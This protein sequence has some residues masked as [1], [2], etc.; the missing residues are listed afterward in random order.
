MPY[1]FV[2]F[3]CR[4]INGSP[5][6][7]PIEYGWMIK[8]TS[9][10]ELF[11]FYFKTIEHRAWKCYDDYDRHTR[12]RCHYTE[13]INH[14]MHYLTDNMDQGYFQR[15]SSLFGKGFDAMLRS[16]MRCGT[17]YINRNYG[18]FVPNKGIFEGIT[19][20]NENLIWPEDNKVNVSKFLDGKHYYAIVN[21]VSVKDK[22]G[23]I[24]WNTY[25]EAESHAKEFL[26]NNQ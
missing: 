5:L 24:K 1:T 18:F 2:K 7:N 20:T 22:D 25:A 6:D 17:V 9:V 11:D 8:I 23:N 21:G 15:L 16:L 19:Q 10:K 12:T 26:K 3:T 4:S 13:E 14:W